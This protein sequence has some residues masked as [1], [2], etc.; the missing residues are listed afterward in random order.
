MEE[1]RWRKLNYKDPSID[2]VAIGR[3]WSELMDQNNQTDD[4]LF[5]A[6]KM[7]K[8]MGVANGIINDN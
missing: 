8:K 2:S 7:G 1:I 6:V 4:D 5:A 3:V